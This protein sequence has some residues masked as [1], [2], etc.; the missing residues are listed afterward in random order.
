MKKSFFARAKRHFKSHTKQDVLILLACIACIAIGIVVLWISSFRLPD[1][2]SFDQRKVSES[3]KIYDR[4]GEVLLFDLHDSVKRTVVS[5]DD[6]SENL[7][8]ATIAIEDDRF[9]EHIGVRP[10]AF[11]RAVIVNIKD[12]GFSQGGSTITQQ[13]VKNTLLTADKS[14]S[15]KIKEWVLAVKLEK[16]ISK[17]RIL[18][19]YLNENPYGGNIYGVQEASRQFFGKTA[20]DVTLAEAS[21]L[22]A[23]P[24]ASTFYSPYGPNRD[25]LEARKNLVLSRMFDQGLIT[26]EEYDVAR[27]ESVVF[28]ERGTFGIK[29]AHFVFFVKD[30]LEGILG[31]GAL[32]NEGYKI[33][34]TLDAGLQ[35]ANEEIIKSS[36]LQNKINFEAENAALIALDPKTGDIL[37]M[38]GS[39][40]Y[41]DKEI[42]G[43]FNA[44]IAPNRQPG[45]TMKP[46]I[47]AQAFSEGY[48]DDTVLFDVQ[49]EFSAQCDKDGK[50]LNPSADPK[51]CYRP[52]NYDDTFRGPITLRDALAQSINVPAV[53]LLYL[54]GIT[55]S[56]NLAR[57]MG[58]T[59]LGGAN[60]YGLTL[61][62]GGGQISLLEMTSAYGVF[63]N[64]GFRVPYRSVLQ[65]F[66]SSGNEVRLPA[67]KTTRA[68]DQ[69]VARTISNIL[70]DNVART[71]GYGPNSILYFPNRDVAVKTGTTNESRDAWTIGYSPN[72]VV[73]IWAG[74]NDNRPMVKRVAGQIVA[75][76][77]NRAMTEALKSLPDERFVNPTK[78][79]PMTL[80]PVMKGVWQGGDAYVIDKIS[81]KLATNF[82]PYEAREERVVPGIHTILYWLDKNNPLGDKPFNPASDPQFD[83]WEYAVRKWAAE[84]GYVDGDRSIIP[85]QMDD[86]HTSASALKIEVQNLSGETEYDPYENLS[87]FVSSSGIYPL[88]QVSLYLN[89][90][91]FGTVREQPFVFRFSPQDIP[92][93]GERNE[94]RVV[95]TDSVYN[96]AEDEAVLRVRL[97]G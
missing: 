48:T 45:S 65:V 39:R 86:V 36:A 3:T 55:D 30:H 60:Q 22:A 20:K 40:D 15:R 54:A 82:T 11:L 57:Q 94:V 32:D 89:G 88:T 58:I 97:D 16:L 80:K 9:Y 81:G 66:D 96:S 52:Q 12:G 1:I 28:Q 24:Q 53:K 34:T 64:D 59:S 23:I 42:D 5:S 41:F 17:E 8:K 56:I 76:I 62:L 37:S 93:L 50:P 77:W 85:T 75:P 38:V 4:T 25:R 44:A 71:P 14:P 95:G 43:Q 63:A 33:I 7:K 29:A 70:S 91:L 73:G 84:R 47:Y 13:V 21:Y 2:S 31:K 69:N 35:T 87:V 74:N 78:P 18:E 61:V 49:T 83:R 67:Q 6:I 90:T 92:G 72:I 68:L 46:I 26:K 79:D 51:V 10:M 27:S 19:I